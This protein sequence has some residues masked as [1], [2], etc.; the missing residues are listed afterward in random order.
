MAVTA[1]P[2]RARHVP[3]AA[4]WAAAV[5]LAGDLLVDLGVAGPEYGEACVASVRERGPYIVLAPGLALAHARP[6]E[7]ATG[8]GV[9]LVRLGEPVVF[10]HPA[11]DPVDLVL[12][13]A[14]PDAE[15]HLDVLRALATALGAGLATDLRAARADD[16]ADLLAGAVT[17]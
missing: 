16:L 1:A 9:V 12:A 6:E 13:F 7:G 14:T 3:A 15:A 11:N 17:R 8:T 5:R 2:T 4:D 10:G